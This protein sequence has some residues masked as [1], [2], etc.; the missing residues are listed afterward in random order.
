MDMTLLDAELRR[1]EGVRYSPY[2][3]T[4]GIP[5]VGV[6]HNL[7]AVHLPAGWTYPL[8]DA[9]VDTLL[10]HDLIV[11]FSGLDLHHPWWR[12]MDEVRQ[13]VLANMAFNLGETRL[14]GFVNTLRAMQTGDY[15]GAAAGMST[16]AWASQVGNRATRLIEAMRTGIMPNEPTA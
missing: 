11:T 8:T 15:L 2:N 10:G 16:S 14:D 1:D 6:G 4:K 5:T 7:Q 3:D 9:Q 12:Q 13:R